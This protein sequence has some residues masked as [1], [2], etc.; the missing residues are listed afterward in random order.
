M[1]RRSSS[2]ISG[3]T[4]TLLTI[5][6]QI[7]CTA[8]DQGIP[9][10]PPS[11][12]QSARTTRP[13]PSQ[14]SASQIA[15]PVPARSRRCTVSKEGLR[16]RPASSSVARARRARPGPAQRRTAGESKVSIQGAS[17]TAE[18]P[19]S[20]HR[21]LLAPILRA[22]H[23]GPLS[24]TRRIP[25]ARASEGRGWGRPQHTHPARDLQSA[26]LGGP[27]AECCASAG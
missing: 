2:T 26:R 13:I 16:P 4:S 9:K 22:C 10:T 7:F 5:S 20:I 17:L 24:H 11:P 8:S 18:E 23:R 3:P 27:S 21:Y 6:F 1:S 19:S 14:S 15:T 12:H 25:A